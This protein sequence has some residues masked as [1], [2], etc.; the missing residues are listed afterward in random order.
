[1]KNIN[2][3]LL[4]VCNVISWQERKSENSCVTIHHLQCN[5]SNIN[6]DIARSN[7]SL[8]FQCQMSSPT[9]REKNSP[10]ASHLKPNILFLHSICY[11]SRTSNLTGMTFLQIFRYNV[12]ILVGTWWWCCADAY[13]KKEKWVVFRF[14]SEI[15]CKINIEINTIPEITKI[16]SRE[17]NNIFLAAHSLPFTPSTQERSSKIIIYN[18]GSTF[19]LVSM[20][21]N[22]NLLSDL[23]SQPAGID[24]TTEQVEDERARH[25]MLLYR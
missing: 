1:M 5:A 13:T 15:V 17:N 4:I 19:S 25:M 14:I 11:F 6:H 9:I 16:F 10:A 18:R 21:L 2:K 20:N 3:R 22:Q 7:F 12:Y 24:K 8:K 23:I